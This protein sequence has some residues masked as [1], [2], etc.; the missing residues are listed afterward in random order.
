MLT[1]TFIIGVIFQILNKLERAKISGRHY[2]HNNG[3]YV[4]YVYGT[5]GTPVELWPSKPK[6]LSLSLVVSNVDEIS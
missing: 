4:L 6:V 2:T 5:Y 1:L 3:K